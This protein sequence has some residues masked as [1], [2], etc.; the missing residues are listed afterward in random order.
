M[1]PDAGSSSPSSPRSWPAWVE[2]VRG[3][4]GAL[5]ALAIAGVAVVFVGAFV[6]SRRSEH[7]VPIEARMP[8][9]DAVELPPV[10]SGEIHVHVAGAVVTPGLYRVRVGARVAEVVEAAGGFAADA[11]T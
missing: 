5:V 7:V 6:V 11:R 1:D 8:S 4:P 10:T 3:S 2:Q 9:A